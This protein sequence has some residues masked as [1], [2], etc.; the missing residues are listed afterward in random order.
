[1]HSG[2]GAESVFKMGNPLAELGELCLAHGAT[3]IICHHLKTGRL[4][5]FAP[6]ELD[7]LAYAG[8]AEYF[9]QWLLLSRREQYEPGS[10][11]HAL[12]LTV[13]GSAGHNSLWAVDID[14]GTID[15]PGGRR[16]GLAVTKSDE[17]RSSAEQ[18]KTEAKAAAVRQQIDEDRADA[19]LL[20]IAPAYPR[21]AGQGCS[22]QCSKPAI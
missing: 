4:N 19:W 14:E 6:A 10:G 21:D 5:Q 2:E 12:W 20:A 16:W 17:A 18:R 11:Q 13:G 22:R 1:M 9:R 8:C 7:D 3:P 15:D